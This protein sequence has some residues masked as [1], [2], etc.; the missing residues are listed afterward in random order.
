MFQPHQPH[1]GFSQTLPLMTSDPH[2]LTD[3]LI[4]IKQRIINAFGKKKALT[5]GK[6]F[7]PT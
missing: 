3:L 2:R 7:G 6:F 4:K 1:V 5:F